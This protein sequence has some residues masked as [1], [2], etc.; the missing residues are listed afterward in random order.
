MLR[1]LF[2]SRRKLVTVAVAVV[3]LGALGAWIWAQVGPQTVPLRV[4]ALEAELTSI[5]VPI[6]GEWKETG[7]IRITL[8]GDPTQAFPIGKL[9]TRQQS[10]VVIWPVS[11]SAPLLKE[12]GLSKVET[13][14]VGV[15]KRAA[16][17]VDSMAAVDFTILRIP[18]IPDLVVTNG[19][20][21]ICFARS[22]PIG[23]QFW[24]GRA[25]AEL[26]G[27]FHFRDDLFDR[28]DMRAIAIEA[29]QVASSFMHFPLKDVNTF[30]STS[31]DLIR[32]NSHEIVVYMPEFNSY[33][34][35]DLTGQVAL[36]VGP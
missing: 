30:L 8:A 15:G 19:C 17:D 4:T 24:Q 3:A 9:D 16:P 26:R 29:F 23:E 7:P 13:F 11:I 35:A 28:T 25:G 22:T 2:D 18:G 27:E 1:K 31:L 12:L 5:K 6:N 14:L 33:Q 20:C 10:G 21:I 32:R 36:R 34:T